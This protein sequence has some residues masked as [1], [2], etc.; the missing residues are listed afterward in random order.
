MTEILAVKHGRLR[1]VPRLLGNRL[2]EHWL[3][4][5]TDSK[6][7]DKLLTELQSFPEDHNVKAFYQ[8]GRSFACGDCFGVQGCEDGTASGKHSQIHPEIGM[9]PRMLNDSH[10]ENK[11]LESKVKNMSVADDVDKGK[12]FLHSKPLSYDTQQLKQNMPSAKTIADQYADI[13]H[14][15]TNVAQQSKMQACVIN[16]VK[17]KS[18]SPGLRSN[19]VNDAHNSKPA[20]VS[21]NTAQAATLSLA[22]LAN[23]HRSQRARVASVREAIPLPRASVENQAKVSFPTFQHR[24]QTGHVVGSLSN[25]SDSFVGSLKVSNEKSGKQNA[26]SKP[27]VLGCSSSAGSLAEVPAACSHRAETSLGM[28][29]SQLALQHKQSKS[30]LPTLSPQNGYKNGCRPSLL[31][32]MKNVAIEETGTCGAAEE[33]SSKLPS[34]EPTSNLSLASCL[35]LHKASDTS[36]K[37]PYSREEQDTEDLGSDNVVMLM[38][39]NLGHS[40]AESLEQAIPT[41]LMPKVSS[42]GFVLCCLKRK[43][44]SEGSP[45]NIRMTSKY[46]KFKCGTQIGSRVVYP[47]T[48]CH[49]IQPFDFSTPS[50]DDLVRHRQKQ[51][52]T[53]PQKE[54]E[55]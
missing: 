41:D 8:G 18:Q 42:V 10:L 35:K 7:F 19:L 45:S 27:L 43:R 20:V 24:N 3:Q 31:Q 46:P 17:S 40:G 23:Q 21:G 33:P 15:K 55:L 54:F 16:T 34:K 22:E 9:N 14:S 30:S 50:P 11:W 38:D 5:D 36:T 12:D 32:L 48:V 44:N 1:D 53:R 49:K 28:S 37:L 2:K 51:A 25:C 4:D 47:E 29:L 26:K 39:N 6:E 52:F 13:K